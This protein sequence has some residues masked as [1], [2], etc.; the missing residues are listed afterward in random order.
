MH[1]AG[2][3]RQ[4]NLLFSSLTSDRPDRK[5]QGKDALLP[6]R[7]GLFT[8]PPRPAL[9]PGGHRFV[10]VGG[11]FAAMVCDVLR[12]LCRL[13]VTVSHLIIYPILFMPRLRRR[14]T[15]L[16]GGQLRLGERRLTLPAR[17]P[18]DEQQAAEGDHD[19]CRR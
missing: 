12:P 8:V 13:R 5:K 2:V 19:D 6:T 9:I 11:L 3:G 15:F 4:H 18:E 17:G 7:G 10:A 1:D 14:H 16:R